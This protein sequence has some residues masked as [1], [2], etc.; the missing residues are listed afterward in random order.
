MPGVT[1]EPLG[2]Q[3]YLARAFGVIRA[4][5][6]PLGERIS[7]YGYHIFLTAAFCGQKKKPAPR[8]LVQYSRNRQGLGACWD[9]WQFSSYSI[10]NTA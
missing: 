3:N 10:I 6:E 5:R 2:E 7:G 1:S 4:I 9:N 8:A